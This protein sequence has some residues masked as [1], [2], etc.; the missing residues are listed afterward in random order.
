MDGHGYLMNNPAQLL[1]GDGAFR[2]LLDRLVWTLEDSNIHH[3]HVCKGRWIIEVILDDHA[4]DER[5]NSH[6]K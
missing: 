1:P 2:Q 5:N 4:D 6:A 3:L